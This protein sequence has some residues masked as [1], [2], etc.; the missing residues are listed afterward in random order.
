M[1]FKVGRFFGCLV[2]LIRCHLEALNRMSHVSD[3]ST[4][5]FRSCSKFSCALS[6]AD[7]IALIQQAII[8]KELDSGIW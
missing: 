8:R 6:A 4:M 3:H 7:S 2:F 1:L 5:V